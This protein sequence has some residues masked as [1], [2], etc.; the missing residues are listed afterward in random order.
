MR[1]MLFD[2]NYGNFDFATLTTSHL[3]MSSSAL[4]QYPVYLGAHDVASM[5]QAPMPVTVQ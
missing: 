5:S 4:L 3:R 2:A 1:D